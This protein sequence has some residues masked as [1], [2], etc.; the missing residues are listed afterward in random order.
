MAS[1]WNTKFG[2]LN[3]CI[4]H[5]DAWLT[6]TP[7]PP[8]P[9]PPLPNSV[10]RAAKVAAAATTDFVVIFNHCHI[11]FR[12]LTHEFIHS[13][14]FWPHSLLLPVFYSSSVWFWLHI[15][16]FVSSFFRV[17][18]WCGLFVVISN[19]RFYFWDT[20][21]QRVQCSLIDSSTT[22][23]TMTKKRRI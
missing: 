13:Y 21:H 18:V 12:C 16:S 15:Y 8:P 11:R 17:C 19:C 4:L 1:S 14:N 5:F 9:P 10:Q 7:P 3:F 2:M 20:L 22:T 23:A 6:H